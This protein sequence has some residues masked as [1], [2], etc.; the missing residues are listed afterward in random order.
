LHRLRGVQ[1]DVPLIAGRAERLPCRNESFD[2]VT[3]AQAWHW[4][5]PAAASAELARVLRPGGHACILWNFRDESVD[6]VA[7]LSKI[8]GSEGT[9]E[10]DSDADPLA[11]SGAFSPSTRHEYW[12][13]QPLDRA[14]L[15]SLVRSRS[16]VAS[17][18][19]QEQRGVLGRVAELCQEHPQLAGRTHFPMPYRTLL[20]MA[21]KHGLGR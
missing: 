9:S 21:Q 5:D 3:V 10:A 19:P 11:S 18:P 7:E 17:L 16:Y 2:L 13:E 15:G 12:F 8:I 6:W 14:L 1:T 20:F 4:F